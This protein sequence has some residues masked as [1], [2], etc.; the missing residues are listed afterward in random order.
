[1]SFLKICKVALCQSLLGRQNEDTA[2]CQMSVT[3]LDSQS[4]LSFP[5][6]C[7]SQGSLSTDGATSQPGEAGLI[8]AFN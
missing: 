5:L 3:G 4:Y 8:F 6:T 7:T 1:M 2:I